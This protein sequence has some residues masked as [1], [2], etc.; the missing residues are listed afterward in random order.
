MTKKHWAR[1]ALALAM[2]A[3]SGGKTYAQQT[4]DLTAIL[5]NLPTHVPELP[6]AEIHTGKNTDSRGYESAVMAIYRSPANA[7]A[8]ERPV[9]LRADIT[10]YSYASKQEA[11]RGVQMSLHITQMAP[12]TKLTT[13]NTTVYKW[14][15]QWADPRYKGRESH[16]IT[17]RIGLY[18][19]TVEGVSDVGIS[20][21]IVS[22]AYESLVQQLGA[23]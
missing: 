10:I 14:D 13:R 9:R 1:I 8:T 21:S 12:T 5:K 11:D 15:S 16:R 3:A 6:E 18:V 2:V 19:V 22:K 23:N 7:K 20:E 4:P 17:S